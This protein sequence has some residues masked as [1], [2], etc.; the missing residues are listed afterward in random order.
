VGVNKY[1]IEE[2]PK[3]DVLEVPSTVR[4][5]QIESLKKIRASRD[6]AAVK[7]ALEAITH[8]AAGNGNLLEACIP[9]VRLRATVGEISDAMEK[10][11]E[12]GATWN[13]GFFSIGSTW[14][15]IALP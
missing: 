5:E 15:A 2:E 14:T 3:V 7:K 13:N 11:F 8:C 4:N 12:P 1:Q 6:N 10:E 9:A